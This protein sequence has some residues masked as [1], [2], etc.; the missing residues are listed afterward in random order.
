M[1][2]KTDENMQLFNKNGAFDQK[3]SAYLLYVF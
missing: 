2:Q 1:K 3:L